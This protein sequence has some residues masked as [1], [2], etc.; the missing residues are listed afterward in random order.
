MINVWIEVADINGLTM[1][2]NGDSVVQF[3]LLKLLTVSVELLWL[4]FCTFVCTIITFD[5]VAWDLLL[6]LKFLNFPSY[7]KSFVLENG[8]QNA[9]YYF[10]EFSLQFILLSLIG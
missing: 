1:L 4:D 9:S 7:S 3:Q 10:L 5:L 2:H 6:Y 8:N